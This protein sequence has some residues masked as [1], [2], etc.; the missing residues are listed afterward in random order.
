MWVAHIKCKVIQY[1]TLYDVRVRL[2]VQIVSRRDK[3]NC[4]R[5]EKLNNFQISYSIVSA[6]IVKG[7]VGVPTTYLIVSITFVTCRKKR[8]FFTTINLLY[9]CREVQPKSARNKRIRCRRFGKCNKDLSA[10]AVYMRVKCIIYFNI[11]LV[12]CKR[13]LLKNK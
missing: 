11:I 4:S 3:N 9:T 12:A 6:P 5:L 7:S 10:A 1:N 13:G 2:F 8:F